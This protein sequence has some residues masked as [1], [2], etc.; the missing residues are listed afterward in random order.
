MAKVK[1]KGGTLLS[2]LPVVLVT[3]RDPETGET[4]VLT[5][6]WTGILNSD[7]PRAYVSVRPERHS[8][9]MIRKSGEFC[10][11]LPHAH[12]VRTV[13]LCGVK[14]GRDTDKFKLCR[15]TAEPSHTVACPS[16]GE[17]PV[18]LECRV[19]KTEELG[20]HTMFMADIT[21]VTVDEALID[22]KGRMSPE[23]A[24]LTAYVHGAY[25]ALGKRIGKFGYSVR[26][27]K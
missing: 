24:G 15:L 2:P 19:F 18:T 14:S 26:K 20:S 16:I 5:V 11:N 7:P 3:C 1:W 10:I 23:K 17:C 21:A 8:Y 9:G 4:D 25:F 12:M 22:E 6:A 27:K 13:D